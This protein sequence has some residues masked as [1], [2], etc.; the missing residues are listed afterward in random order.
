MNQTRV[1]QRTPVFE[2]AK[3]FDSKAWSVGGPEASVSDFH[4]SAYFTPPQ[5]PIKSSKV[6][7][8]I[9]SPAKIGNS[10]GAQGSYRGHGKRAS[11]KFNT[12]FLSPAKGSSKRSGSWVGNRATNDSS[13]FFTPSQDLSKDRRVSCSDVNKSDAPDLKPLDGSATSITESSLDELSLGID[14]SPDTVSKKE[15]GLDEDLKA[16][17]KPKT[18]TREQGTERNKSS[19]SKAYVAWEF[20]KKKRFTRAPSNETT[21]RAA[22]QIQRIARGGWQRLKYRIALLEY[23]LENRS[24]ITANAVDQVWDN[25]QAQKRKYF[26]V[27]KTKADRK[28]NRRLSIIQATAHEGQEVIQYLRRDNKKMRE[29]NEKMH[30]KILGMKEEN[31]HLEAAAERAMASLK[32]IKKHIKRFQEAHDQLSK[33]EPLFASKTADS[34]EAVESRQLV[35]Q[36]EHSTKIRYMKCV[37]EIVDM[38]EQRCRDQPDLVEEVVGYCLSAGDDGKQ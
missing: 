7:S 15:E 8:K 31:R 14:S 2:M 28:S 17:T 6:P 16:Q 10:W 21:N 37:A 38:M 25:L 30:H 29:K 12:D 19:I 3:K 36:T 26:D 32:E 4:Q 11:T 20:G 24:N 34:L 23:K 13:E 5:S 18:V 22:V 1:K 35:C 27:M 9:G 33:V